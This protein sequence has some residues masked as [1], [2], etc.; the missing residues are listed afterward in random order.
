MQ[1]SASGLTA[2]DIGGRLAQWLRDHQEPDG[3]IRDPLHGHTGT[4][5]AGLAALAFGLMQA[6]TGD[7]AWMDAC[8]RS[9]EHALHRP[10][11]SEFDVFGLLLLA[12]RIRETHPAFAKQ[13][14]Q[15]VTPYHGRRLVSNNWIAMRALSCSLYAELAASPAAAARAQ[16]LWRRVL[17]WQRE[18]GLF[19]DAPAGECAPVTYHAKFCAMV[20]L[21]CSLSASEALHPA[22]A[23]G[24][25]VLSSL[26]TPAGALVPYGRSRNTLFG[27]AAAA[28]ALAAGS[29]ILGDERFLRA[30]ARVLCR[31]S[32]F[33][34]Q[35][36]HV[37]AVLNCGEA[38]KQ[39]WDVYIN[40]PDYNAYA[41]ALLL[42]CGDVPA[43]PV[44]SAAPPRACEPVVSEIGPIVTVWDGR[45]FAAF[46]GT[47]ECVPFGTPFFC[48]HRTC[49]LQPLWIEQ[50]GRVLLEPEPYTWNGGEDRSALVDPACNRW[51]PYVEAGGLR[52]A[53]RTCRQLEIRISGPTVHIEGSGP[54][55]ALLPLPRWQRAL[56][57]LL[58]PLTGRPHAVFRLRTLHKASMRK[59]I[60]WNTASG[61]AAIA[62]SIEGRLP[63][64]SAIY[65][66]HSEAGPA[67]A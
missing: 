10:R 15:T 23:R 60:A 28:Y 57:S 22:L 30:A 63:S 3:R 41:A 2:A 24:L 19:N 59:Y 14:L 64:R 48:D 53:M 11:S 33:Q 46:V 45:T 55:V 5:A 51:M 25:E 4:Y 44:P 31:L 39:D 54:L 26:V 50:E 42:L 61:N 38:A 65:Q 12:S 67:H 17:G 49:A 6:R 52:Y 47:G 32:A 20:A 27:Y 34:H 58:Y 56:G 62:A 40:N 36:G 13:I 21:Q 29:A 9:A 37:P 18:D 7:A 35:D 43:D 1:S 8:R 16:A 66:D